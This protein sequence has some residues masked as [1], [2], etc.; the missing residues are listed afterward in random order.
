M[1]FWIVIA[2]LKNR[3]NQFFYCTYDFKIY[4][5]DFENLEFFKGKIEIAVVFNYKEFFSVIW[6]SFKLKL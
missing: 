3:F 1:I 4:L 2:I 6:Y 5:K